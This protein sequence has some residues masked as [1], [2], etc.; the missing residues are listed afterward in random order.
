MVDPK[1]LACEE[2]LSFWVDEV[3]EARWYDGDDALDAEIHARYRD[4]WAY[5]CTGGYGAWR[6]SADGMLALLLLLDQ[7]PRNMFRGSGLAFSSDQH[8]RANAVL[9]IGR[10][11]DH[12]IAS[13]MRQF[14][15]LPMMHSE[16]LPDQER[17]IRLFL[18]NLPEMQDNL[19]HARVHREIIRRYSR[20]P[21]RNAA[22]E[23]VSTAAEQEFLAHAGYASIFRSMP[24]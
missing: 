5:A 21:Y 20:F 18:L 9:A 22:L 1:A 11:D 16:F 8:A 14:F 13:P 10:G 24:H 2:I 17:C 12:K 4:A 6:Q 19:R 7:F 3:G 23:R 15:Y